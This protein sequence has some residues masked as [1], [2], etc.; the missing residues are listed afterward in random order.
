MPEGDGVRGYNPAG[1]SM[2]QY[3]SE[4]IQISFKCC[5]SSL[6]VVLL[7]LVLEPGPAVV[8]ASGGENL[9][10]CLC[11]QQRL[12]KLRRPLSVALKCGNSSQL[13]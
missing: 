7:Q 6:A 9:A 8:L 12:L 13:Q 10:A 5:H 11:H 4:F 2:L 3:H 1:T